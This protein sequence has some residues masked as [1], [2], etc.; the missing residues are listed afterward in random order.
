MYIYTY[1]HICVFLHT[2][3]VLH[4]A[5]HSSNHALHRTVTHSS[6]QHTATQCNT[7]QHTVALTASRA[8][9]PH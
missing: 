2:Y 9:E 8:E 3:V 1:I 6:L 4:L 5:Q 7:L